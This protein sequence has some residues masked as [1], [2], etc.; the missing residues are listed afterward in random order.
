MP[1]QQGSV[2]L[3]LRAAPPRSRVPQVSA[4]GA[5]DVADLAYATRLGL[6]G[7]GDAHPF[8]NREDFVAA[9]EAGDVAAM[10]V[11][12]RDPK[13]RG[14]YAARALSSEGVE[15]DVPEHRLTE[16][17][18]AVDDAVGRAFRV[19]HGNLRTALGAAGVTR[20]KTSIDAPGASRR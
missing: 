9:M 10:E 12:A 5:G 7:L 14:L 11:M 1:S 6:Y 16:D 18:W 2:G 13:T 4:T 3:H 15:H 17:E 8:P 19:I 20:G